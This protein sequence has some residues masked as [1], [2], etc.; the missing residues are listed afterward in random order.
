[1]LLAAEPHVQLDQQGDGNHGFGPEEAEVVAE[2]THG[3]SKGLGIADRREGEKKG[4]TK[5]HF[6]HFGRRCA[7]DLSEIRV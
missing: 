1:M 4:S 2:D 7:S 5:G 3:W 6:T